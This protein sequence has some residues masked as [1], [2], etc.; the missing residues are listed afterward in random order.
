MKNYRT[1]LQH[2]LL[3]ICCLFASLLSNSAFAQYSNDM[4]NGYHYSTLITS[5]ESRASQTVLGQNGEGLVTAKSIKINNEN[6]LSI[7]VTDGIGLNPSLNKTYDVGA[8][9]QR[10]A[11]GIIAL[12]N[13]DNLVS[14]TI[15][16]TTNGSDALMLMRLQADGSIIWAKQY[17]FTNIRILGTKMTQLSGGNEFVLTSWLNTSG[18]DAA[19]IKVDDNGTV[20]AS[21]RIGDGGDDQIYDIIPVDNNGCVIVGTSKQS[22]D[23]DGFIVRFD[24]TLSQ[25]W[26]YKIGTG[27]NNFTEIRSVEFLGNDEFIIGGSTEDGNS[28]N[29]EAFMAYWSPSTTNITA[30]IYSNGF[31]REFIKDILRLDDGYILQYYPN[32]SNNLANNESVYI[33]VDNNL[34]HVWTKSIDYKNDYFSSMQINS[35]ARDKIQMT[36]S[37]RENG[38]T[39]PFITQLNVDFDNCSTVDTVLVSTGTTSLLEKNWTTTI[40]SLTITETDITMNVNITD[41]TLPS[42]SQR[43]LNLKDN[44]VVC[45][46][47]IGHLGTYTGGKPAIW[48]NGSVSSPVHLVFN[49]G[50]YWAEL[51]DSSSQKVCYDTIIVAFDEIDLIPLFDTD[52]IP[53]Y[54]DGHTYPFTSSADPLLLDEFTMSF[55]KPFNYLVPTTDGVRYI[56]QVAGSYSIQGGINQVISSAFVNQNGSIFNAQF[57]AL[58]PYNT[59]RPNPDL[60]NPAHSYTYDGTNGEGILGDGNPIHFNFEDTD[61]SDN[62]GSLRIKIFQLPSFEWTPGSVAGE[63]FDFDPPSHGTYTIDVTNV[64]TSCFESYSLVIPNCPTSTR[65]VDGENPD[66]TG[67]NT[68]SIYRVFPNPVQNILKIR[69]VDNEDDV[70]IDKIQL[71]N[72]IGQLMKSDEL[73]GVYEYSL[74][75][76]D[77][78]GGVYILRINDAKPFKIIKQ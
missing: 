20:L 24:N 11:T 77:L 30:H 5:E 3:I 54:C 16:G 31:S 18:D 58:A 69:L 67:K 27:S 1:K 51:F 46:G 41:I 10:R 9:L 34:N 59:L 44:L 49:E 37:V 70:L 53:C 35:P 52:S 15:D 2:L 74:D 45:E 21:T 28:S 6:R 63:N 23:W 26:R 17:Q 7:L 8:G 48:N 71:F 32:N 72:S 68:E 13:G 12:D 64:A 55:D 56:I 14:G 60:Y 75:V 47:G 36:G 61:Y 57:P 50:T 22:G 38:V 4:T 39:R 25:V 65:F 66:N 62:W 73:G 78:D 43:E 42:V 29:F 76:G 40:Q 33:K 19:L